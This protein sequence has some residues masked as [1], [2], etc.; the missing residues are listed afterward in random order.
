MREPL[1]N[2]GATPHEAIIV[3]GVQFQL[4]VR[5]KLRFELQL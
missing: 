3:V 2:R 4:D 5:F 1:S